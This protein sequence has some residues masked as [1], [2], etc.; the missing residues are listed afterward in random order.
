MQRSEREVLQWHFEVF[1]V[2]VMSTDWTN[3]NGTMTDWNLYWLVW[4]ATN[5]NHWALKAFTK[6]SEHKRRVWPNK[7][8]E[9]RPGLQLPVGQAGIRFWQYRSSLILVIFLNYKLGW[10][11]YLETFSACQVCKLQTLFLWLYWQVLEA[12]ILIKVK[13]KL[14]RPGKPGSEFRENQRVLTAVVSNP[15]PG[16]A[17]FHD[18]QQHLNGETENQQ[19]QKQ[20]VV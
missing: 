12:G 13:L 5:R 16:S 1:G 6:T 7:Y 18:N 19:H 10:F 14:G 15:G 2:W 4:R 11:Q 20:P 17:G 3:L 9:C 8:R